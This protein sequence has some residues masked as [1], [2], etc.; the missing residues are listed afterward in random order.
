[1]AREAG[2]ARPGTRP[3]M[4]VLVKGDRGPGRTG[5]VERER[6]IVAAGEKAILERRTRRKQDETSATD[7][8][9]ERQGSASSADENA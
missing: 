9:N 3:Q 4:V 2:D 1:M 6:R 5:Q 8:G 7:I